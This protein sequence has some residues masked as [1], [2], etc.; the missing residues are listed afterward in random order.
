MYSTFSRRTDTEE[1]TRKFVAP[2]WKLG[3]VWLIELSRILVHYGSIQNIIDEH[4]YFHS[5]NRVWELEVE[6]W[7]PK[8]FIGLHLDSKKGDILSLETCLIPDLS[9]WRHLEIQDGDT[10]Y[11]AYT[12]VCEHFLD[13]R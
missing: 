11:R 12:S 6:V 10:E 7:R 8:F 5:L 1:I 3:K 4:G 13:L 9:A 2:P